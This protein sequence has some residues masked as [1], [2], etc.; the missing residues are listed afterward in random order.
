MALTGALYLFKDEIDAAVYAPW[1]RVPVGGDWASPDRWVVAA[2]VGAGGRV[3]GETDASPPDGT[4][5]LSRTCHDAV[6][7]P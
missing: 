3:E 6:R 2:S 4:C 7:I 5:G 1:E